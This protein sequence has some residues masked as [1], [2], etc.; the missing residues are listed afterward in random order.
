MTL[1]AELDY[2][3]DHALGNEEESL[4]SFCTPRVLQN[5]RGVNL[6]HWIGLLSPYW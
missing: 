3:P 4:L 6:P 5:Y 1:K 2:L